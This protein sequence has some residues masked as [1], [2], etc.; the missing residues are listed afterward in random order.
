MTEIKRFLGLCSYYRRFVKDFATVAKPLTRL[1]EK[2]VPFTWSEAEQNSFD[3]LKDLTSTPVMAYPDSSAT[4]ILDTDASNVGIG[5]VL[6]QI[7]EGEERVIA[8]GSRILTKAERQYCI[9]RRELLAVVHFSRYFRHYL[10]G[11]KFILRTDHASLRWLKSFKEPEGQL[12]RWLEVLDT[13]DFDLQHRPGIKHANADALSRGPCCQCSLDHD[14][15]K[16]RRGRPAGPNRARPIQTRAH[17]K[18]LVPDKVIS[19]S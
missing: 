10:T 19:P 2:N 15:P 5:A 14:G 7:I 11:R 12:A 6:S 3:T 13:F 8:Y 16:S 18:A 4:F 17:A 9:T 1:T